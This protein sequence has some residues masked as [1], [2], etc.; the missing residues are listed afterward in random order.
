MNAPNDSETTNTLFPYCDVTPD[1]LTESANM[2]LTSNLLDQ[3]CL[4]LMDLLVERDKTSYVF[5]TAH[6]ALYDTLT[7]ANELY[8][9]TAMFLFLLQIICLPML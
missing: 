5:W 9:V 8:M 6:P 1:I 3:R 4:H 7:T 2:S